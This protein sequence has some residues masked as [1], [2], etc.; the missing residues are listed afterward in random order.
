MN[1]A[2]LFFIIAASCAINTLSAATTWDMRLISGPQADYIADIAMATPHAVYVIGSTNSVSLAPFATQRSRN[3]QSDIFVAKLAY[4]S[5]IPEFV[6]YL[7]GNAQD[8]G[9]FV[10]VGSNGHVFIVAETL[11]DDLPTTGNNST[12]NG[13]WDIYIAELDAEGNLLTGRYLGGASYDYPHAVALDAKNQL[14]VAG[15]TWSDDFPSTTHTFMA[16]CVDAGACG[17]SN[18]F[19]TRV[20]SRDGALAIEYVS[21]F[22]GSGQDAVHAIDV[23][24]D[25]V[26]HIAGET[27]SA[28]L[29]LVLPLQA[30][31]STGYDGFVALFDTSK[32]DQQALLFASFL[33]G[34]GYDSLR[35]IGIRDNGNTVVA[36]ETDSADFPADHISYT[37]TCNDAAKSCNVIG[38]DGV[39]AEIDHRLHD[40]LRH[41]IIYGGSGQDAVHRIIVAPDAIYTLGSTASQDLTIADNALNQRCNR[42]Y[43]CSDTAQDLFIAMWNLDPAVEQQLLY[44]SYL[45]GT[46]HET[47]GGWALSADHRLLIGGSTESDDWQADT[48]RLPARQDS[49][50][51][52]LHTPP[53][54][55]GHVNVNRVNTPQNVHKSKIS[56]DI[57][58][59]LIIFFISL[60]SIR[61]KSLVICFFLLNGLR[62]KDSYMIKR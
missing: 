36:G 62:F 48:P 60:N 35:A 42:G 47:A 50:G 46:A 61:Y 41:A 34:S 23:A 52:V 10:R 55:P 1:I 37:G 30:R 44:A 31:K 32:P 14:Y 51:F 43:V 27:D 17:K 25:G 28:D 15:E 21:L 24:A 18:G 9:R 8:I 38:A 6:T 45:G 3:A 11:S 58:T 12:V 2:K 54:N 26:V 29:P 53:I 49:D 20:V 33:G 22:G 4:P 13:E 5:L 19:W 7:S 16:H 57:L 40:R 39:L 59:A 56:A